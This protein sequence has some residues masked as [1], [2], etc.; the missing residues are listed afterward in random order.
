MASLFFYLQDIKMKF[1]F[2]ELE[3]I[4]Q[5]STTEYR[6]NGVLTPVQV[7][8]LLSVIEDLNQRHKW[9][10]GKDDLIF[11]TIQRTL[12]NLTHRLITG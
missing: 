12:E 8:I 2:T 7:S 4:A 1:N 10:E 6:F 11:D 5:Q 3:Q 9:V